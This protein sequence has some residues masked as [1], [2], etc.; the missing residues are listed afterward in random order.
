[1]TKPAAGELVEL[2]GRPPRDPALFEL[3]LTHPSFAHEARDDG[4]H[5]ERLEFLGDAVLDLIVAEVLYR[6]HPD[7]PEGDLSRLRAAVVCAP[8]LAR[9][10]RRLG[11][12]EHLRLG[13]GEEAS[14]G[15]NRTSVLANAL[16]AFLGALYLS[17]GLEAARA[18][19]DRHFAG[20]LEDAAAGRLVED[21]KTRL[22]EITQERFGTEPEYRVVREEG[23]DHAKTFHVQVR[24]R[25]EVLGAGSGR[26]KKEAEQE[27]ARDA[28]RR[29]F[30]GL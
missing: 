12:G 23:P 30:A 7:L 19:V 29:R 9:I 24:L 25:D 1:M 26:N 16:E 10:A 20:E 11:L 27:A 5:N 15:R 3:A 6:R 14:G 13:Q 22:Q 21:F 17:E 28:L 18:F 2:I 8:T 4:A